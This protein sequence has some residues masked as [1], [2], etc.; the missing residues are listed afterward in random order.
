M[1]WPS[2]LFGADGWAPLLLKGAL[3]TVLLSVTS[4]PLGFGAGLVLALLKLSRNR[5]LVLLCNA[6]TNFFRGIPDLLALFIVYFGLQSLLNWLSARFGPEWRIEM[7]AF[8]AG[9]IALS[10]VIAAYSSEVW[11]A[12]LHAVP[13]GQ[14]DAAYALGL[15]RRQAF[16]LVT[17]PQLTRV[18]LPGLGN[19]W[20]I[21]VKD[22]SLISTLAVT[23]LLRAASEASRAT[24]RPILFYSAAALI[25]LL[26]SIA[27][28]AVQAML[29]RR[30]NRGY[31]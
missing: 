26:F 29:E 10:V 22:T 28:G 24:L 21:L 23:D 27:S 2:L 17:L 14:K 18:A 12:S 15:D 19:L 9:V 13:P 11:V 6:Y 3:I 1:T 4:A 25:Y 8:A 30:L 16:T 31:A 5:V 7:D 20:T